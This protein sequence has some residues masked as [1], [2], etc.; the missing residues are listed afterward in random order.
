MSQH[1]WHY[2]H[3]GL[4]GTTTEV[5]PIPDAE[6]MQLAKSGKLKPDTLVRC[7]TRQPGKW[8]ALK[9]IPGL[10]QQIE[11]GVRERALIKAE[12]DRR[13]EEEERAARAEIAARQAEQMNRAALI[14]EQQDPALISS[15]ADCVQGILT[16]SEVVHLI[17]VQERPLI[18]FSPD[19]VVI[20][21]RRLIF[22]R[23]KLLGRFEFED[24]LLIDLCN[25]HVKQSF[26]RSTFTARHTSGRQLM[27]DW[28]PKA[29]AQRLYRLAQ[30]LEERARLARIELDL[31]ARRAGATN[32]NI[33]QFPGQSDQ[34]SPAITGP[35][36]GG[37]HF[38]RLGTLKAMLDNGLITE[39]DFEARKS[40][41]LREL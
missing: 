27:M 29:A 22:C 39:A 15:I 28:L 32:I 33:G 26:F 9:Q 7:D 21:N 3:E 23:P 5:G 8:F 13:R 24:Y 18:N 31:Q 40:E 38:Q 20:T 36:V 34:R 37:D 1:V 4:M 30:E 19:A 2:M 41:I 16:S 35:S 14:S 11:S 25:A 17:V 10:M 6:I 12:T